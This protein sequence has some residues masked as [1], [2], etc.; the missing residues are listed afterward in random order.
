MCFLRMAEMERDKTVVVVVVKAAAMMVGVALIA[1][2]GGCEKVP[3]FEE[4]TKQGQT[5]TP[6]TAVADDY[7]RL[8]ISSAYQ[9][10]CYTQ[11]TS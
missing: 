6:A 8:R 1:G 5:T 2:S 10:P 4:L 3:T 11:V 9:R 7:T